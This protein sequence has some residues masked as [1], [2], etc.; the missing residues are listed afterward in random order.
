MMLLSF[1]SCDEDLPTYVEPAAFLDAK[2]DG[3]Y[4]LSDTEHAL[5]LY[6]RITNRYEETLSGIAS[7]SGKIVVFAA[8]DTTIRKTLTLSRDNLVTGTVSP[9]GTLKIDPKETII[10]KGVW[11]FPRNRIIDD[12]GREIAGDSL[13][14]SFFT[15]V[16]DPTCPFRYFATPEDFILQGTVTLFSQRAPVTAGPTV[17][18]FCFVTNFVDVRVCPRIV[19]V[20]PCSNWP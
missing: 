18:R 12:F 15:F 11:D 2:I 20:T 13:T 8:R 17:F 16:P 4:F 1:H 7:L 6:L 10:L 19:T 5:R 9:S 3:E 14:K